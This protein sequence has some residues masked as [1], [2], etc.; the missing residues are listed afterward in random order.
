MQAAIG[1]PCNY[2][3]D[4]TGVIIAGTSQPPPPKPVAPAPVM[5]S[6]CSFTSGPL[7]LTTADFSPKRAPLG[8]PCTDG[9]G[10]HGVIVEH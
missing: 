3:P 5:G 1:A 6:V 9:H 8:T 4:N 10:S 7:A 2:G